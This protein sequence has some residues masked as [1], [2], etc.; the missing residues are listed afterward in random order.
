MGVW[1]TLESLWLANLHDVVYLAL[2]GNTNLVIHAHIH[3]T[4]WVVITHTCSWVS[5]KGLLSYMLSYI[6]IHIYMYIYVHMHK[7]D[8][9]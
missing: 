9:L 7:G 2:Q 8:I 5:H 3:V 1:V 4:T 6:H